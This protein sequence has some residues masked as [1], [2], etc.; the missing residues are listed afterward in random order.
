MRDA[1]WRSL[2][3]I[4]GERADLLKLQYDLTVDSGVIIL[5]PPHRETGEFY[6]GD[7]IHYNLLNGKTSSQPFRLTREELNKHLLILGE[8]GAGKTN[9]ISLLLTQLLK[10]E[11]TCLVFDFKQDYRHLLKSCPN[12]IVIPWQQFRFNPLSLGKQ[13]FCDVFC[14]D[15]SLLLGSKGFLL[16]ALTKLSR[17]PTPLE[18]LDYLNQVR[19]HPASREGQYLA[20]VKNRIKT[21]ILELGDMINCR[22]GIPIETLLAS[23]IV[24][25]LNGLGKE[26]QDFLV[27][28]LLRKIFL[29][30]I[31]KN[32]RGQLQHV[33]VFDEAKRVFDVNKERRPVEGIP[34]IDIL[35]GQ[36]REFGTGL[37]IA[38]QEPSKLTDSIKANTNCKIVFHL[39]HGKDILEMARTIM[40][41]QQEF[42]TRLSVGQAI[43]KIGNSNPFLLKIPFQNVKKTISD[44]D[45]QKRLQK[46][47]WTS[48]IEENHRAT[49]EKQTKPAIPAPALK[50]NGHGLLKQVAKFP[51]LSIRE[52]RALLG[53]T[54]GSFQRL[55]TALLEQGLL[56]NYPL[57]IGNRKTIN[58]LQLTPAGES[59]VGT[60]KSESPEHLYWKH[61]I[62]EHYEQQ[63]YSVKL[64]YNYIDLV[65]FKGKEIIGNEIETGKSDWKGNIQKLLDMQLTKRRIWATNK[66][67]Y[68]KIKTEVA[69][70]K[71][72]V[73]VIFTNNF[74]EKEFLLDNK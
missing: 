46:T 71:I 9:L 20:V 58:L 8:T 26:M 37:I 12:L 34:T 21:M 40:L 65:A 61:R 67:I 50:V 54:P 18:L 6:L 38:D 72:L 52:R 19:V 70:R 47:S 39:G 33:V 2:R 73:E 57:H 13:E 51:Y 17:N 41:E 63:G 31:K 59:I 49:E 24:L 23:N 64:E 42:L 15:S 16:E 53:L 69:Q 4:L 60:K 3:T 44:Q 5:D 27:N 32:Q 66:S 28:A 30:R 11:I 10:T 74:F 14:Q 35:A 48:K 1:T 7:V 62:K 25:E 56:V 68:E 45:I 43:T 29:Y 55:K 22:E 36:I